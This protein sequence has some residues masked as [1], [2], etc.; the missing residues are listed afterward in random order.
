MSINIIESNILEQI[1]DS[2]VEGLK[3]NYIYLF[4]S[5]AYGQANQDINAKLLLM[6]C[7][8]A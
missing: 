3:P 2:L 8:G 4:G 1:I 5:Q 7:Y 6:I